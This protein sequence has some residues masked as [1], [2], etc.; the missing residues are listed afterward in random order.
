VV[1]WPEG[2]WRKPS[3]W[4]PQWSNPLFVHSVWRP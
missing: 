2:T 4:Q 3:K 1:K